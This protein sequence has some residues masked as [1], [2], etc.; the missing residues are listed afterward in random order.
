M[1]T[2]AHSELAAGVR[3]PHSFST[4][5]ENCA[6][7]IVIIG[8]DYRHSDFSLFAARSITTTLKHQSLSACH[9]RHFHCTQSVFF[10]LLLNHIIK[11]ICWLSFLYSFS[12]YL[13]FR[14]DNLLI[15]YQ[16]TFSLIQEDDNHYT[17]INFMASPEQ[18]RIQ[19][20]SVRK[21]RE[22]QGKNCLVFP[23]SL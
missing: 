21:G 10:L 13:S 22:S 18:V 4:W 7:L 20:Q 9:G 6:A 17:A 19:T 1:S 2:G 12:S 11:I 8:L 23:W 16:F 5:W 3:Y 14:T 15:D